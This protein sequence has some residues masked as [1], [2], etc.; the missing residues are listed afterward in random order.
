MDIGDIGR[1][2]HDIRIGR[3][4]VSRDRRMGVDVMVGP[5]STR[6]PP[7]WVRSTRQKAKGL[8][9]EALPLPCLEAAAQRSPTSTV[10][11]VPMR[12]AICGL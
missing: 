9:E 3:R 10:E 4:G 6:V 7:E 11:A 12:T 2:D 5:V 1:R 8:P